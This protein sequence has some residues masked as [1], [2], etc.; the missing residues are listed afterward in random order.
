MGNITLPIILSPIK[1]LDSALAFFT[2][3]EGL[4]PML[5]VTLYKHC[6]QNRHRS[7][8]GRVV[9]YL[10]TCLNEILLCKNATDIGWVRQQGL[11]CFH[12][13]CRLSKGSLMTKDLANLLIVSFPHTS[14][15]V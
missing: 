1:K 9:H 10:S 4:I 12:G 11:T 2:M 8:F 15:P 7:M 13:S 6:T 14:R 3:T 5:R